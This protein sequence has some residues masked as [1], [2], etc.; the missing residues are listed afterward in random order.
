MIKCISFD[1][2]RTLSHVVPP[3]HYYIP[4]L[5]AQKG[6]N[7]SI[8]DFTKIC[9]DLLDNL[10]SNLIQSYTL[11]GTL[12]QA[13]RSQFIRNYN[14]ARITLAYRHANVPIDNQHIQWILE[15]ARQ[16]QKKILYDDVVDLIKELKRQKYLLFILSGNHSDGIIELLDEVQILSDFEDIITVDKYH[17]LKVDNYKTLIEKT[18]L[19][20]SEILHIGDD[21]RTDGKAA[22]YGINTIIIRRPKQ[23]L[24]DEEESLKNY[25][26][27]TELSELLDHL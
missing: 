19:Q 10:P 1:F 16:N 23:F 20:P 22:D 21:L 24:L 6:V 2:D 12:S 3:T 25:K 27:I 14:L 15:Q 9:I 5:L 7:I 11:Y 17:P 26:V 18:K 8:D 4:Q 13:E